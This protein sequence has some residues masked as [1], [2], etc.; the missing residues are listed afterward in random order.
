MDL[1]TMAIKNE[2]RAQYKSVRKFSIAVGIPQS[3]I[4]SALH[5]G[6]GGTS[7]S[8][9]LKICRK[10]SINMYDFSPLYNTN[11]QGMSMM[12]A[13]SQLDEKGRYIIDALFN[14]ELKRCKGVDY[15]EEIKDTIEN[16]V[17]E[18]E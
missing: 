18:A 2:I 6:I 8:T 4:V 14:L 13:Y 17:K 12:A 1:L 9:V 10:L 7:Y 5:N 15:T 3:T 16:A 11:Y